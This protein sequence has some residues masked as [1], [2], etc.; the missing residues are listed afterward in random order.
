MKHHPPNC[1]LY[2]TD[3]L[4]YF[5]SLVQTNGHL[6]QELEQERQRHQH[7]VEQLNWSYNQLKKT[8]S[9][10]S[11]MLKGDNNAS[12]IMYDSES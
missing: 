3:F 2:V 12:V 7:E 10:D 9:G 11:H 1:A 8:L 4:N 6:L 5:R